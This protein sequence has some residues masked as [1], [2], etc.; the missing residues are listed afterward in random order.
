MQWQALTVL[1]VG[2][3]G[4]NLKAIKEFPTWAAQAC[5]AVATFSCYALITPPSSPLNEW[6]ING[7]AWCFQTLGAASVMGN[8]PLAPKTDSH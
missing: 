2:W 1:L 3:F 6:V 5:I 7:V 4:Q 8:T